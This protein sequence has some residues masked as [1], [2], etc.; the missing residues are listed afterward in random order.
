MHLPPEKTTTATPGSWSL[1]TLLT[2]EDT[3]IPPLATGSKVEVW[4]PCQPESVD[5]LSH[6][7]VGNW[8]IGSPQH[9]QALLNKRKDSDSVGWR[10]W[11]DPQVTDLL[12]A[13]LGLLDHICCLCGRSLLQC[14]LCMSRCQPR[15]S[16]HGKLSMMASD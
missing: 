9:T 13:G 6:S 11:L 10:V 4:I 15:R 14:H 5:R 1:R 3:W 2:E 8:T 12:A 7:H 16:P